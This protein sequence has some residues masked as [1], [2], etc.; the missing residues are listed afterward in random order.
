ML[1]QPIDR[2]QVLLLV[3]RDERDRLAAGPG[4]SRPA[5]PVFAV[6]ALSGAGCRE[7]SQAVMNWL[8]AHP[9]AVPAAT[10]EAMA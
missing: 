4:A 5:G 2:A 10:G 7:L 6:S 9:V 1:E 3:G 8:E